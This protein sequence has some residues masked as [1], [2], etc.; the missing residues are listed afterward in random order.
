MNRTVSPAVESYL[1]RMR[2]ALSD[3][4]PGE[5]A[6]VL[7]DVTPQL[8]EVA[9]E[10]PPGSGIE[11]LVARFDEPERYAAELRTAA[12][13][14]EGVSPPRA[15]TSGV[16][17]LAL[18]SLVVVSALV[19]V[20]TVAVFT[21]A[22]HALPVPVFLTSLLLLLSIPYLRRTG[23]R[24]PEVAALFEVRAV[25]SHLRWIERLPRQVTDYVR[26]LQPAWWLL[27]AGLVAVALVVLSGTSSK[28]L[29]LL[30]L[31]AAVVVASCWLGERSRSDRRWLWLVVPAN[32]AAG[33]LC[34]PLFAGGMSEIGG[35]NTIIGSVPPLGTWHD[36]RPV[37]NIYLFDKEGRPLT[38][39]HLYDEDGRSLDMSGTFCPEYE[40]AMPGRRDGNAFPRP[41]TTWRNGH[42]EQVE[43]VPFSVTVPKPSS[44]GAAPPAPT[45]PSPAEPSPAQPT[46]TG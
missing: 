38:D 29:L 16:A 7:E 31:G 19:F 21:R 5:V 28:F 43:G 14:P 40:Y 1:N 20:E 30:V 6:E 33:A 39:V 18:W 32:V 8:A 44:P 3:L 22:A 15:T 23:P 42:C 34:L 13:Y 41:A 25:A 26:S 24:V 11:T 45:N 9:A 35:G 36:G 46:P 27:R 2:Q 10:Q 37:R 12:G 17:R 4:P